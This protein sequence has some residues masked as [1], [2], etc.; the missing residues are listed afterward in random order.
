MKGDKKIKMFLLD[1]SRGCPY[2]CNFCIHPIKSGKKW[3]VRSPKRIVDFIE[4]LGEEYNTNSFRF[5]GSNTPASLK[6]DVAKEILKRGLDITYASFAETRSFVDWKLLR[7]SGNYA[8]VFGV[9]SGS[10]YILDKAINKKANVQK[11]LEAVRAC[12]EAGIF[13]V[14]AMIIPSPYETESTEKESLDFLLETKPDSEIISLPGLVPGTEW[15]NNPEKYNICLTEEYND[16]MRRIMKYK[17]KFGLPPSLW[18]PL[19]YTVNGKSF[20]ECSKQSGNFGRAVES[21]GIITQLTDEQALMAYN[22]GMDAREFRDKNRT[23]LATG[24]SSQLRKIVADL[25]KRLGA[26]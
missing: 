2:S 22:L 10:Q 14:A 17:I 8:S 13:T 15:G 9:E 6:M 5:S 26:K 18:E 21:A 19:P 16:S 1:E 23:Y 7:E 24:N 12:K 11:A 20:E 4:K 3:R 25:N